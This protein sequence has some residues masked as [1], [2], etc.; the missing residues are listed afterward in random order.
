M[1]DIEDFNKAV[2]KLGS[3]IQDL[4]DGT[5]IEDEIKEETPDKEETKEEVDV[6]SE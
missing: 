3:D 5:Q 1:N 4:V 2:A 6:E